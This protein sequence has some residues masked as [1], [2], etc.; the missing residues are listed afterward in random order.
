[1]TKYIIFCELWEKISVPD[2]KNL[3]LAPEEYF[4]RN[5]TIPILDEILVALHDRF[6]PDQRA[7]AQALILK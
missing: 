4:K 3:G 7:Y 6:G 2:I 1:M 5:A